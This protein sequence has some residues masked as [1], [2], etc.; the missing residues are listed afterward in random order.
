MS[1]D[2]S[3]RSRRAAWRSAALALLISVRSCGGA[4]DTFSGVDASCQSAYQAAWGH[5]T[6]RE[7]AL[8][9]LRKGSSCPSPRKVSVRSHAALIA[10]NTDFS[11]SG[12]VCYDA[13]LVAALDEKCA[14]TVQ[15]RDLFQSPRWHAHA[16]GHRLF[17]DFANIELALLV[18]AF[19]FHLCVTLKVTSSTVYS[20][21]ENL[22]S[23]GTGRVKRA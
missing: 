22:V 9:T 6:A 14:A 19:A 1:Y 2:F 12:S 5:P 7:Y 15:W 10:A 18:A 21:L 4:E 17:G 20:Q 13:A 3:R 11:V 23:T 16:D 8:R